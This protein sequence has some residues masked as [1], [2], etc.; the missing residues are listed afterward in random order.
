MRLGALNAFLTGYFQLTMGLSGG[1]CIINWGASVNLFM[2][3]TTKKAVMLWDSSDWGLWYTSVVGDGSYILKH[4]EQRKQTRILNMSLSQNSQGSN[5]DFCHWFVIELHLSGAP[6]CSTWWMWGYRDLFIVK[7][8]WCRRGAYAGMG[9]PHT[10]IGGYKFRREISG[11]RIPSPTPGPQPR[12]P[13]PG[14]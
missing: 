13:V 1:N 4:T 10:H 12:V 2:E 8:G 9:W 6:L 11:A 5:F 14:I 3:S 7:N